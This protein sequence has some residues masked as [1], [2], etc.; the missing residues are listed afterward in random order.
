MTHT[1]HGVPL[2]DLA[3]TKEGEKRVGPER[4][5]QSKKVINVTEKVESLALSMGEG[6]NW[7][8]NQTPVVRIPPPPPHDA[9][10]RGR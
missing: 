6:T 1:R 3:T 5:N 2:S 9:R 8:L 4:S 10:E 7:S